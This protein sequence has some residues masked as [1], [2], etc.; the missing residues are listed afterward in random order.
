MFMLTYIYVYL[1]LYVFVY[2][3]P[4]KNRTYTADRCLLFGTYS[5]LHIKIIKTLL[6]RVYVV[7]LKFYDSFLFM[8][9][10]FYK[11][12]KIDHSGI[13]RCLGQGYTHA[14]VV[15]KTGSDLVPTI[16]L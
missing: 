15:F 4:I 7:D 9:N 13:A 12:F 16:L 2:S 5:C 8:H 1:D 14:A 10:Y 11:I 6:C 3:L